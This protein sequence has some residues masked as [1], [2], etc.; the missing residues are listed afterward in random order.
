MS[1]R[2]LDDRRAGLEEAFFANQNAQLLRQLRDADATR[3]GKEALSAASGIRDAAVLDK[4]VGLG[5]GSEAL[6]ALA[7]VPLVAVAWADGSITDQERGAVL[8]AAEKTG[9]A[10]QDAGYRLLEDWLRHRP[11]PALLAAW[12]DYTA[13]LSATLDDDARLALRSGV[14]DRARAVAEA[15]GGFLGLGQR[16]S[17]AEKAMLDE[18]DQAFRR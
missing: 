2:F 7:L 6:T 1:D 9:L 11:P 13:A 5:I 10:R 3:T 14:L 18:L 17:A 15:A 16:V 8:A 12:K 4:L